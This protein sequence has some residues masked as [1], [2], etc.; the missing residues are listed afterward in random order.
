MWTKRRQDQIQKCQVFHKKDTFGGCQSC[1]H[2]QRLPTDFEVN[3]GPELIH[4]SIS[5]GEPFS[6]GRN[7]NISM[8]VQKLVQSSQRR[9][10]GNMP[11]TLAGGHELLL[12]HQELSRS[13]EDHRTLR[14]ME[15]PVF[16]RQGQKDK[17]LV[18]EPKYISIDQKKQL[19]M[20]PA[21]ET[22][23]PVA[24]TSSKPAPEVSKEKPKRPQKKKTGPKNHQANWHRPYPQGYRI[25]KLEPSAMDS[26][27][28]MAKTL[29]EFTA[30]EQERM[31][32]TFPCK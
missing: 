30:K 14:R 29:M 23:A 1:P 32:R 4:D 21:L 13:G 22:E 19:E 25:P 20:T 6:N 10:V 18:E 2:S 7:R 9:G 11:K 3:S 26:V 8:P 16:Q 24:S 27:F 31:N 15:T 5:R 28:N 12:T 17:E